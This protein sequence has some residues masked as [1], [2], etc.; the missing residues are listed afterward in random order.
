LGYDWTIYGVMQTPGGELAGHNAVVLPPV[1]QVLLMLAVLVTGICLFAC[2]LA[3]ARL[4]EDTTA[5]QPT[6]ALT[7]KETLWLLLPFAAAYFALLLPRATESVAFDR[8]VMPLVIVFIIVLLRYAQQRLTHPTYWLSAITLSL[9]TLYAVA[10]THD[11]F[12]LER[13][14]IQAAQEVTDSG[15]PRTSLEGGFEY[16]GWTQI[17]T[18]GYVDDP[19]LLHG[20][21]AFQRGPALPCHDAFYSLVPAVQPKYQLAFKPQG[22]FSVSQFP[23]VSFHTW[24]PPF[25]R[26]IYIQKID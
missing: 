25:H 20:Y 22:C 21:H 26:Q 7:W 14:R 10:G 1:C 16:D 12:A 17:T 5:S 18:E 23:P 8:Y 4:A 2:L 13:A 6:E 24:M 11:R 19:R 9:F 3:P 15:V